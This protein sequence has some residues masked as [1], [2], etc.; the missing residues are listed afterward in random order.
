MS[1]LRYNLQSIAL[2]CFKCPAQLFLVTVLS[3]ATT[4]SVQL[5]N[6]SIVSKYFRVHLSL[7]LPVPNPQPQKT[8]NL[9]SV[10]RGLPLLDISQK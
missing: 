2:T 6:I 1:L 3:C 5:Q 9:H 10:S 8:T 4:T 7:P